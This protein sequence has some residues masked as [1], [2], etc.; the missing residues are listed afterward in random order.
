MSD[1]FNLGHRINYFL[2]DSLA[3]FIGAS[4]KIMIGHPL[5]T[6]K[7]RMQTSPAVFNTLSQSIRLTFRKEGMYG[8]YR[9]LTPAV[10]GV[11]LYNSALFAAYG[12]FEVALKKNKG[13][14]V[15][16]TLKIAEVGTAGMAA[17]FVA[18]FVVAPIELLR[19]RLQA[20]QQLLTSTFTP[21]RNC[22]AQIVKTNGYQ[23]LF[24][25]LS[26]SLMREIPCNAFYFMVY[27]L[28]IRNL[29]AS[30][31]TSLLAGGCA[32]LANW[33]LV[34]PIDVIKSRYTTSLS[35]HR[36][37]DCW[38]D[39]I[40]ESRVSGLRTVF[41]KGY[42]ACMARAF[43]ANSVTFL[44]VEFIHLLLPNSKL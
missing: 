23:G 19:C 24:K 10:P 32:G 8:F 21:L 37:R 9:G 22:F 3:G 16:D 4:A 12:Q 5:D 38:R 11:W 2:R 18:G 43:A 7:V 36:I 33:A 15:N 39:A 28:M 27:E 41:F 13:M 6:I 20:S 31:L 44:C 29:P 1:E 17:G 14:H 30:P 35:Y 42:S 40:T 25:G 26:L 34:F